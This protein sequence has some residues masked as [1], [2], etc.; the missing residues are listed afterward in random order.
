MRSSGIR[1]ESWRRRLLV[2]LRLSKPIKG[3]PVWLSRG[4][5]S[6]S[7]WKHLIRANVIF[8]KDLKRL[9]K[10]KRAK[11]KSINKRR[12][13]YWRRLCRLLKCLRRSKL[14]V[15]STQWKF[16]LTSYSIKP[17]NTQWGWS[18]SK[19]SWSSSNRRGLYCSLPQIIA[20][21][22]KRLTACVSQTSS[23]DTISKSMSRVAVAKLLADLYRSCSSWKWKNHS[24]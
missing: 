16:Y 12:N 23:W 2:R 14:T 13:L 18:S 6:W 20:S 7:S 10:S 15:T 5:N 21:S 24:S 8:N 22:K 9:R 11:S 4:R 3:M 17:R 1:C 19:T